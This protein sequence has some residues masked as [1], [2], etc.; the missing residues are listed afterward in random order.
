MN[1]RSTARL[2]RVAL[3]FVCTLA[4]GTDAGKA[5]SAKGYVLDSACAF[6]K[7]LQQPVSAECAVAWGLH[8]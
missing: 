8:W 6:T 7:N 5:I 3:L 4:L 1:R 2:S